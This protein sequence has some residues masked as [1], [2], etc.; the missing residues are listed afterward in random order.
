MFIRISEKPSET[1]L[2][3]FKDVI[4]SVESLDLLAKNNRLSNPDSKLPEFA[5]QFEKGL[6]TLGNLDRDNAILLAAYMPTFHKR[7]VLD[8]GIEAYSN[9]C[10]TYEV[11]GFKVFE[12]FLS[13][14][15]PRH[16]L[17]QAR[18]FAQASHPICK[19]LEPLK[20]CWLKSYDLYKAIH[21]TDTKIGQFYPSHN[22]LW[23]L[24]ISARFQREITTAGMARRPIAGLLTQPPG[25]NKAYTE[26]L[27]FFDRISELNPKDLKPLS[28]MGM[29]LQY[30][31]TLLAQLGSQIAA[32]DNGFDQLYWKPYVRAEKRLSRFV[33]NNP[34]VQYLR[35]GL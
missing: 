18:P 22:L 23:V 2:K 13:D 8:T 31:D 10:L 5:Y 15:I 24:A 11:V 26:R 29:S 14:L 9:L 32:R 30:F 17:R 27:S 19:P 28:G 6:Q 25:K 12:C 34:T 4:E 35:E 7:L 1:F 16:V 3:A 33:N 20:D 21:Q